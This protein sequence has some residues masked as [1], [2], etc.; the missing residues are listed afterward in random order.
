MTIT[1]HST[2][3]IVT[4]VDKDTRQE[5]KARIW[6][7]R[8]SSGIPV[9]GYVTRI[10]ADPGADLTQFAFEIGRAHV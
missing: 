5:M 8:T 9:H 4:V 3:K 6:E 7:G 2:T 10:A 1:I